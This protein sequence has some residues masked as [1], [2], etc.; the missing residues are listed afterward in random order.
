MN[1]H[2]RAAKRTQRE[3][4]QLR[5]DL[6]RARTRATVAT[7]VCPDCGRSMRRNNSMAGWYQCSQFG[8]TAFRA[9]PEQ[10]SCDWQGFTE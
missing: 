8:S 1:G 5:M 4:Q 2:A 9:D 6:A 3:A 7:G 10:P